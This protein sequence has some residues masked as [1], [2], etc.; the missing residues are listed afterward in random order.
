MFNSIKFIKLFSQKFKL[1]KCLSNK[2]DDKFMG[3]FDEFNGHFLLNDKLDNEQK[4][5]TLLH[6]VVHAIDDMNAL[7]IEDETK[8]SVLANG[9]LSFI[10]ENPEIIK[11]IINS[12]D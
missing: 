2:K 10:R 11:E 1:H 3:K 8:I 4:V 6:E 9:F 5:I 7:S 12:N